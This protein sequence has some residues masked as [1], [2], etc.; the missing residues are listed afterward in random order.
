MIFSIIIPAYNESKYLESTLTRLTKVFSDIELGLKTTLEDLENRVSGVHDDII[1]GIAELKELFRKEIF[2]TIQDDILNN[3]VIQLDSSEQTMTEFWE[4]S[5]E[6]SLLSFKDVWF[7]RSFEGIKAH[8]ITECE[9]LAIVL[10]PD[11]MLLMGHA[12]D[13]VHAR[14]SHLYP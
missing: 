10:V 1:S 6:V 12:A 4:R 13:R 2:E 8:L 3:I 7:V 5:K 11:E 9:L 14:G